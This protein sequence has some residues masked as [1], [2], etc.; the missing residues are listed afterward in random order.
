MCPFRGVELTSSLNEILEMKR[1]PSLDEFDKV[2][3]IIGKVKE[4]GDKALMEYSE[5]FDGVKPQYIKCPKDEVDKAYEQVDDNL[6]DALELARENL[7]NFHSISSVEKDIKLD[8]EH[9]VLGKKYVPLDSTG[10]YVPGGR[11]SYPSTALMAGIPAHIAGVENIAACT[12]PDNNGVIKPL[13]LVACDIAGID[14]IYAVG[15]AHAIAALA[16][17][18]ETVKKVDKI[19]GPGNIYV[20]MAK[21][22]VQNDVPM[23]MPAGPSEVLIIADENANPEFVALDAA[24]QLEHD[25]MSIAVIIATSQKAAD[26]IMEETQKIISDTEN[27]KFAVADI[28]QAIETS[29]EF[30][31]EHLE[32]MFDRAEEYFDKVKHAGSVFIGEYSPVAAGDYATGTNHILPTSGYAR[33]YSGLSVETFL[34]HI[35]YQKLNK[36]ALMRLG[37]SIKI[38]AETEGLYMH[39]KSI[40]RR[41]E[42]EKN[43]QG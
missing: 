1:K 10:I 31:P 39:A 30:A 7:E 20:T 26:S 9:T 22:L 40:E 6:I 15:G 24:A 33:M 37:D 36:D 38:L 16:Y 41:I 17:G 13:T 21:L 5:K 4:E 18:T 32:L 29:N 11:A 2:S 27:L 23:D 3:S 25:P 8:F 28:E 12:P 19:V 14:Q 35:T 43:E 42:G 34:K